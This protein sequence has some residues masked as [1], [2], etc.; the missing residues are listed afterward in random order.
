MFTRI[1]RSPLIALVYVSTD[2]DRELKKRIKRYCVQYAIPGMSLVVVSPNCPAIVVNHGYANIESLTPFNERTSSRIASISKSITSVVMSRFIEE[3]SD[4][5]WDSCL[6]DCLHGTDSDLADKMKCLT[7][8]RLASHTS[9]IR[10]YRR[11]SKGTTNESDEFLETKHFKNLSEAVNVFSCDPFEHNGSV[12]RFL[13]TTHG[14]TL[15]TFVVDAALKHRVNK[16]MSVQALYRRMFEQ[17]GMLDTCLENEYKCVQD[18]PV[19]D[20]YVLECDE[21]HCC[22][23]RK[24]QVI[25]NSHKF[26]GGGILSTTRD[27]ARFGLELL[28]IWNGSDVGFIKKSSLE[29]IWKKEVSMRHHEQYYGLGWMIDC[30]F[31]HPVFYHTGQALGGTS[32]LLIAPYHGTKGIA[33]AILCNSDNCKKIKQL[34]FKALIE[35]DRRIRLNECEQ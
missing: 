1:P 3:N 10:H 15:L 23:L 19:A 26:G 13:Y 11:P 25:D 32:I 28:R 18:C 7:L 24:S 9:G 35:S 8:R 17:I 14:Y 31:K 22:E 27:L 16:H 20:Q 5:S 33:L 12:P 4:L 21:Q 34:A 6:E 2:K 29:A 30:R